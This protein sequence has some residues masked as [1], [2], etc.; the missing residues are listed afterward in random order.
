MIRIFTNSYHN[1]DVA[2]HMAARITAVVNSNKELSSGTWNIV[3]L[4]S[5]HVMLVNVTWQHEDGPS[6]KRQFL[7]VTD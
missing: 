4:Y 5:H 6:N 2:R 3:N 7:T 1:S